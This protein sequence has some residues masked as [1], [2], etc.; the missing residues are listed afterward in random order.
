MIQFLRKIRAKKIRKCSNSS[1]NFKNRIQCIQF[2]PYRRRR[3]GLQRERPGAAVRARRDAGVEAHARRRR[4]SFLLK[5][6]IW[7]RA[8]VCRICRS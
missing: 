2:T 4:A 3:K 8:K 7:S 5:F 1:E 6:L